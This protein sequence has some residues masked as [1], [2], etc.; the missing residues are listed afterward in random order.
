MRKNR[1]IGVGL[2]AGLLSCSCL[3]ALPV[4]RAAKK[5]DTLVDQ[6]LEELGI[7]KAPPCSD[8]VFLRR[9]Y[10]DLTGTIPTREEAEAFLANSSNSRRTDLIEKLLNSPKFSDYWTMKWCEIL[11]VK[12][13]FPSNLWPNAVQAYYRWIHTAIRDNMPLDRFAWMLLVSSGSN[14]RDGPVNFYRAV[15]SRNPEALAET[16]VLAFMGE[17]TQ[18]W[19][20][21]KQ[22]E[23][24]AFFAGVSYK[25][26]SEWK[27]EIIYFDPS[28]KLFDPTSKQEISPRFPDGKAADIP[29]GEDPRRSFARWLISSDAFSRYMANRLWF[30]LM[31]RGIVHQ[32][33]DFRPDNPPENSALLDFLANELAQNNYDA[34]HL[35]RVISNSKTYQRAC[36]PP[37]GAPE[38]LVHFSHYLIRRLEAELLIDAICQITQTTESYSSAI[39]EPFTWIPKNKRAVQLADGSIT[40]P[41]LELFGRPPRDTGYVAERNNTPSPDQALHMLN[42]THIQKKI[43]K[44]QRLLGAYYLPKKKDKKPIKRW[45]SNP[46]TIDILYLTVLSRYPTSEE[47]RILQNALTQKKVNRGDLLWLL[48]NSSEFLYR[49]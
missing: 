33:D 6:K 9:V 44:N 20:K 29:K 41:F 43:W 13:E 40:S 28:K 22:L 39:P 24:A 26:T 34:R 7:Q 32:P 27:E 35:L 36:V 37:E 8:A 15:P 3:Y 11:R 47:K 14:F 30:E 17:R 5:L 1:K 4:D 42:S 48:L 21:K 12:S 25:K 23:T 46:E 10:L 31:G 19:P 16:A 2:L 18:Y 45:K 49:H 38:D